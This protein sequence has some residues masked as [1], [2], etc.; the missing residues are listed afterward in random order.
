MKTVMV[1]VSN[2][3]RSNNLEDEIKILITMHDELVFEMP[4]D[5]LMD[6]IPPLNNIMGLKDILQDILK[7]PVPLTVDAEYGDSWHVDHNFFKEH[8]DLKSYDK[9][10]IFKGLTQVTEAPISDTVPVSAVEQ[11]PVI[12]S[13]SIPAITDPVPTSESVAGSTTEPTPEIVTVVEPA[14]EITMSVVDTPTEPPQ[15]IIDDGYLYYTIKQTNQSTARRIN[16]ILS[17]LT[18][19]ERDQGGYQGPIKILRLCDREGNI[20]SD[21][22]IKVRTDS[23]ITLART[24]GI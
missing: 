14:P 4:S 1:R 2:W 16:F 13:D 15:S 24:L 11:T 8:P 5:K 17:I 23:F 20:L 12:Q 18:D 7:W 10:I 9:P 21:S 3:I 22:D 19:Y 6:Y